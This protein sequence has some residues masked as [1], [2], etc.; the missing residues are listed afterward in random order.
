MPNNVHQRRT[1]PTRHA[2]PNGRVAIL[3]AGH[4]GATTAFALMLRALFS[5]IVLIDSNPDLARAEA[6]DLADANALARPSTIWAGTYADAAGAGIAILTAGGAT[7]GPQTRLSVAAASAGIVTECVDRLI[8][9]GFEGIFIIAANPVD[10]MSLLA[11]RRSGFP[12]ARVIGTGTLL[13]SSRL[14]QD[15]AARLG[16]APGAVDGLV[17]GEHGDS[18]VV[19]FSALRVGG[20]SVKGFAP[21]WQAADEEAVARSVRDAAYE[22]IAAKGY[23]SFGVATAIVRICEAIVRDERAVLPVSTLLTGQLGVDGLYLSLP[24]L[25][26]SAGVERVLTP[27]LSEQEASAFRSSAEIVRKAARSLG[28]HTP[29][30]PFTSP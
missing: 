19:A 26:G 6:A 17:L 12:S 14:H 2:L 24:C 1:E 18:E 22:I 8:A 30:L 25:L 20:V 13:D 16:V 28:L 9:A 27:D 5:E 11:F 7:H 3:G 21:D 4:V 29:P 23:T 10:V 15:V